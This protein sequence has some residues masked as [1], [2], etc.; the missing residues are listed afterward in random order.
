MFF[1]PINMPLLRKFRR[2]E[3]QQVGL[4]IKCPFLSAFNQ[5]RNAYTNF[6]KTSTF[7]QIHSAV[8]VRRNIRSDFNNLPHGWHASKSRI[9]LV[10]DDV[11]LTRLHSGDQII[12]AENEND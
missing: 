2:A 9:L 1:A 11:F 4:C 10:K 12:I 7:I 5:N 6:N 3:T 8:L